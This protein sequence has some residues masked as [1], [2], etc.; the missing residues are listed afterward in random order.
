MCMTNKAYRQGKKAY[1]NFV[2]TRSLFCMAVKE[3]GHTHKFFC[4]TIVSRKPLSCLVSKI[5]YEFGEL[6]SLGQFK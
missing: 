3:E 5:V 1:I 4:N 2:V 6:D